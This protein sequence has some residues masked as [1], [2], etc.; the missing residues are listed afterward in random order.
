MT[1]DTV[2]LIATLVRHQRGMVTAFD[3]WVR[4][5]PPSATCKELVQVLSVCSHTL[6]NLEEQIVKF[7][8]EVK[9]DPSE[10]VAV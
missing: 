7:D 3:K 10:V 9:S 2:H 4:K 6:N 5:Q 1:P 8:V